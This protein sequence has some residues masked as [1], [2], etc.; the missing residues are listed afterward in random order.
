MS[1]TLK[2]RRKRTGS[3]SARFKPTQLVPFESIPPARIGKAEIAASGAIAIV[4]LTLIALIWILTSHAVQEQQAEIRERAEQHLSGEAATIAETVGHELQMIDQSLAI[5]RDAWKQDSDSVDLAKWQKQLPALT[6]V[7]DDLFICDDQH[8]IRH[9]ILPKAIG[10]GVGAAYVTFPHGSLEQFGSDGSNDLGSLLLQGEMGVPVEAR[11][12]LIYVVQPLDHPK[13]WLIGASYRSAE[14]TRLFAQAAL[15]FNPAVALI[16]TRRGVLQAIVGP[17]ARHPNTDLSHTPLFGMITRSPS[18][19]WVGDSAI[20]GIERLHAFH[21]IPSRDMVVLVGASLAGV[22]TLADNLASADYAVALVA[23]GFVLAIAGL[24]FWE[25]YTLRDRRRLKRTFERH[26]GELERLRAEQDGNIARATLNAARLHVLLEHVAEGIALFDSS[27]RLVQWNQPFG[28]G[29]GIAPRR[30]MP[31]DTMLREQANAGLFGPVEDVEVEVARRAE[32][33]RSGD[34]TGS[35]HFGPRREA[36]VLRGLPTADSGFMLLLK[37]Q[38]ATAP[39]WEI[40][41][42]PAPSK[43]TSAAQI[44]R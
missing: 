39:P 31:L 11:E 18:G 25:L 20:D 24:V 28:L 3:T 9:D 13:G 5:L 22:M 10:Q 42:P 21:S 27:L 14:L 1:G 8:I 30:D 19:L 36:L 12:F 15:G 43:T 38:L 33:L 35:P 32:V 23:T 41:D 2:R 34:V 16:D 37:Y 6:A 40:G 17:A 26:R 7:A 4:A 44:N 29:I